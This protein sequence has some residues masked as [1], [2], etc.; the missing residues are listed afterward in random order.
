MD[1]FSV[2]LE[3]MCTLCIVNKYA[4]N[5]FQVSL[6]VREHFMGRCAHVPEHSVGYCA[7]LNIFVIGS[8]RLNIFSLLMGGAWTFFDGDTQG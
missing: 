4:Q 5:I 6:C 8:A 7:R 1:E 2:F 3:C